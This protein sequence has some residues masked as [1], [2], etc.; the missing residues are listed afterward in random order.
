MIGAFIG[1][2]AAWTWQNERDK[3]YPH[4]VSDKAEKSVYADALLLTAKTIMDSPDTTRSEFMRLHQGYWGVGNAKLNAEFDVIRSIAIGWFYDSDLSQVVHTYCLCDEKEEVYASHFLARLI[5]ALRH[6]ATKN[7]AAKVEFCGT[8]R[9]FTKEEHWK[10][11]DGILSYLVRAWMSFYDAFD[12]GSTIHN[13]VKQPGNIILN[14]MLAGALADAM[15]GCSYYFVKAKYPGGG[16]M[17]HLPF[18]DERIYEINTRNRVFF[19]KNNAL[20]NVEKHK[21]HDKTCPMCDKVITKEL[22]RRILKAF[23]TGWDDRYGFYLDDGWIYVYRSHRLLSRFILT[24]QLDGTYRITHYQ[25]S[26]ESEKYDWQ[27]EALANAI[28]SVEHRWNLVCDEYE[29]R[30]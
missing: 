25:K 20:T 17:E 26:E 16:Y 10:N 21:W 18:L 2:L 8:F 24:E 23:H 13:A 11:G 5:C 12:F 19:P 29:N 1:D 7:E 4:L 3:F 14:C 6:G 28:Y 9:S 30:L 27:N 15:Y 22:R